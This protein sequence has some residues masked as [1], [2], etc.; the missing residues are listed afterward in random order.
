MEFDTLIAARHHDTS[1]LGSPTLQP[2]LGAVRITRP[3]RVSD[4]IQRA[5]LA[6]LWNGSYLSTIRPAEHGDA[7]WVIG[8]RVPESG[9][10]L[11]PS[12]APYERRYLRSYGDGRERGARARVIEMNTFIVRSSSRSN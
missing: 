6:L 11:S 3:P 7:V 4:S 10:Y 8:L 2:L 1:L 5:M 12:R 9:R